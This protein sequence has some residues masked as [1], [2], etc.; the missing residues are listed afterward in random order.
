MVYRKSLIAQM[1]R[2]A[3]AFK[4]LKGQPVTSHRADKVE[5]I[6]VGCLD[7]LDY[8]GGPPP[9]TANIQRNLRTAYTGRARARQ[10]TKLLTL[11]VERLQIHTECSE[12]PVGVLPVR[13]SKKRT[14]SKEALAKA[15]ATRTAN[16]A[17]EE[18]V[19]RSR[20]AARLGKTA[21]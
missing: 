20:V 5:D 12:L 1:G 18:E 8:V 13:P 11:V 3:T 6:V 15:K 7:V 16:K 9:W 2:V 14:V 17:A 4:R 21:D 19:F 10:I